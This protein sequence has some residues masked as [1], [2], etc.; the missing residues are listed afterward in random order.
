MGGEV[1]SLH[2]SDMCHDVSE[3]ALAMSLCTVM[4]GRGEHR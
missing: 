4:G 2:A 1:N 3:A